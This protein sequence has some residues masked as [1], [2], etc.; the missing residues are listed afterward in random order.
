MFYFHKANT[1][2]VTRTGSV[3]KLLRK[4]LQNSQDKPR[5]VNLQ[6]RSI[7]SVFLRIFEI[8]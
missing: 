6:K 8:F 3:K 2:V 1:E 5:S 4:L 7:T